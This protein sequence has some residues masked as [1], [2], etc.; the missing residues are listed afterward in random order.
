MARKELTTFLI[1]LNDSVKLRDKWR[2]DDK[3]EALL[4]QWGLSDHPAL[5]G[6][7]D[8]DE[9]QAAVAAEGG[10]QLVD[11]WIR[12]AGEPVSNDAYNANA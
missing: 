12:S 7:G 3:R 2:D 5:A 1:A 11:L 10:L 8:I 9:M 4:E 6:G